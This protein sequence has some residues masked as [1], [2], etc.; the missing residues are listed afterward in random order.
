MARNGAHCLYAFRMD[1]RFLYKKIFDELYVRSSGLQMYTLYKRYSLDPSQAV[2]FLNEYGSRGIVNIKDESS[3]I[4]TE[5]G[6]ANY[7]Q[8]ISELFR[9]SKEV[10]LD[11]LARLR[12]IPIGLFE[13]YIPQSILPS[14]KKDKSP[15]K[16]F[17]IP[18]RL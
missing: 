4:L 11:Y 5:K 3:I 7:A 13:P 9:A 15:A 8:I 14:S 16:I 18:E 17:T 1:I 12:F 10:S 2:A 6:K